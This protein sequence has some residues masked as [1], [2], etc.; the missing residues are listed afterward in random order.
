[1]DAKTIKTAL[2]GLNQ[3]DEL[4]DEPW[5]TMD[6]KRQVRKTKKP[7]AKQKVN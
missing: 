4:S 7:A 1:V 2:Y 3:Y 6:Y 5:F